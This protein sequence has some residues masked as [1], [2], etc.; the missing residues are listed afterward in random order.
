VSAGNQRLFSRSQDC[1]TS[2]TYGV[3]VDPTKE[4]TKQAFQAD[5]YVIFR[6]NGKIL[7]EF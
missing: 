7:S 1:S 4:G 3:E 5:E 6:E 2:K